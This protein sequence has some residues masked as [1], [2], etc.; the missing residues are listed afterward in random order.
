MNIFDVKN[1]FFRQFLFTTFNLVKLNGDETTAVISI[2]IRF[3][4]LVLENVWGIS[5]RLLARAPIHKSNFF[6]RL[7]F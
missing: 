1:I 4:Y 7:E 2:F 6:L 3:I 5:A